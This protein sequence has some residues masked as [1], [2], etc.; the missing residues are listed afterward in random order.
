MIPKSKASRIRLFLWGRADPEPAD[1]FCEH[2]S[3]KRLS[4][5]MGSGL[6]KS[7]DRGSKIAHLNTFRS[8]L[9]YNCVAIVIT[10]KRRK[11]VA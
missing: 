11:K 3:V 6:L 7:T 5:G 2:R 10:Q 9:N 8:D 1:L 4:S